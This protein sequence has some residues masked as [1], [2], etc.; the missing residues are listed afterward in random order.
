MILSMIYLSQLT[1]SENKL[2]QL[3]HEE[4]ITLFDYKKF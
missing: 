3:F 4:F 1:K 2:Q